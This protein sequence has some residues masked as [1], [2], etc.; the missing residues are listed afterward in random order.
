MINKKYIRGLYRQS[1]EEKWDL[2]IED[3]DIFAFCAFCLD[4]RDRAGGHCSTN[5]DNCGKTCLIDKNICGSEG[6]LMDILGDY[7]DE[8]NIYEADLPIKYIEMV[9]EV[10]EAIRKHSKKRIFR[11]K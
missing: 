1:L 11:N 7:Y 9:G 6:S 2:P 5:G 3:M 10:K 8:Y 4:K